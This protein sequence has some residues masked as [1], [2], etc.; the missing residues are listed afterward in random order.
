MS[1]IKTRQGKVLQLKLDWVATRNALGPDE[2][3]ALGDAIRAGT[4]DEQVHAVVLC[5]SGPAFCAGGNLAS[6]VEIARGGPEPV[7]ETIYKI[8]HGLFRA[9]EQSPIPIISAVEGGAIGLGADLALSADVTVLGPRGW[10]AQGW[11]KLHAIPATG[12]T[13]YVRRRTGRSGVWQFLAEDRVDAVRAEAMGLALSAPDA[14]AE[15]MRLALKLASMPR[16]QL[17]AVRRLSR[18][19]DLE[20]HWKVALDYQANFIGSETFI[21]MAD[22]I[23]ASQRK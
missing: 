23:L 7:R 12:G 20:E 14:L 2:G 10:L 5:S 21:R 4:E 11:M 3:Q 17:S 15:A 6:L 19:T 8:F 18:I 9:I 22:E 13:E 1:I 16:P